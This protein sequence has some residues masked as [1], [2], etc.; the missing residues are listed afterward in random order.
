MYDLVAF[1]L[2]RVLLESVGKMRAAVIPRVTSNESSS[3]RKMFPQS[4]CEVF[5]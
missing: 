4:G 2:A 5:N 3:Q 1:I